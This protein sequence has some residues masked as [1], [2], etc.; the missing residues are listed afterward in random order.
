MKR[1]F[2]VVLL[3]LAFGFWAFGAEYKTTAQVA[4]EGG[5]AVLS[6]KADDGDDAADEL[7]VIMTAGGSAKIDVGGITHL[8]LDG[9][10]NVSFSDS[11]ATGS[12]STVTAT[13]TAADSYKT[14]LTLASVPIEVNVDALTN[15]WGSVKLFDF[16]E[17]RILVHGVT[18]DDLVITVTTSVIPIASGGDFSLGS[19]A[20]SSNVLSGTQVNFLP[21]TSIDPITN[22]VNNA[23]ASSAQIDGTTTPVDLY[24]NVGVDSNDAVSPSVGSTNTLS[25]TITIHWANLGDY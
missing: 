20:A 4:P 17:G 15:A 3:A 16:P 7:E 13:E 8:T 18:A 2:T 1:I 6:I 24:A 25:G 22:A 21:S 11:G 10:G 14:V 23:L 12:V 5:D 9:S 19:A